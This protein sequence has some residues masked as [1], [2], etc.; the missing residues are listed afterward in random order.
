MFNNP[1]MLKTQ[2]WVSKVN[3]FKNQAVGRGENFSKT[4]MCKHDLTCRM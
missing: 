3:F 4:V 2:G 1:S